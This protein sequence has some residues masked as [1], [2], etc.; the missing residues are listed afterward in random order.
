VF[1]FPPLDV[2]QSIATH[3]APNM[4][5][6]Y[7]WVT[8][9]VLGI[10]ALTATVDAF[11]EVIP[12]MLILLGVVAVAGTQVLFGPWQMALWHLSQ[13]LVIGF[14]I[15]A[16]NF[17]WYTTFH[18]DALGMGDAKWTMLA[19]VCFGLEPVLFAWGLGAVLAS[20]YIIVASLAHHKVTRVTFG[21]YLFIGLCVGLYKIGFAT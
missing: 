16:A 9:S 8:A 1:A 15:W 13:A 20:T 19:I 5:P 14:T 11:T 12:D 10:L 2:I 6:D 17:V 21:P 7:W 4:P 18:H 3:V